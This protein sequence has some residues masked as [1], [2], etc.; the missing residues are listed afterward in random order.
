VTYNQTVVPGNFVPLGTTIYLAIATDPTHGIAYLAGLNSIVMTVNLTQGRVVGAVHLPSNAW[1]DA[2]VFDPTSHELYVAEATLGEV[3]VIDTLNDSVVAQ[4]PAGSTVGYQEGLAW[5]NRTNQIVLATYDSPGQLVVINAS[6]NTVD[7]SLTVVTTDQSVAYDWLTNQYW[8]QSGSSANV[9]VVNAGT[10]QSVANLSYGN[11]GDGVAVSPTGSSVYLVNYTFGSNNPAWVS[12]V[13]ASSRLTQAVYS[14][15][16]GDLYLP[17][18][19]VAVDDATGDVYLATTASNLTE[20]NFTS[21]TIGV[22]PYGGS[23]ATYLAYDAALN[24]M[25]VAAANVTILSGPRLASAA[26]AETGLTLGDLALDP[27][28]RSLFVATGSSRG[29]RISVAGPSFNG[30]FYETSSTNLPFVTAP[31]PLVYLPS[32]NELAYAGPAYGAGVEL[33]NA[34]TGRLLGTAP[35]QSSCLY[36]GAIAV[37]VSSR[38]VAYT[39]CS[40]TNLVE[41]DPVA[42]VAAVNRT[43]GSGVT[44]AGW[45]AVSGQV[46]VQNFSTAGLS[47]TIE[48]L[49]E[50]TLA[51]VGT[52]Q[53]PHLGIAYAIT[54]DPASNTMLVGANSTSGSGYLYEYNA[55]SGDLLQSLPRGSLDYPVSFAYLSGSDQMAVANS[56]D[57]T[58]SFLNATSLAGLGNVTVGGSPVSLAFDPATGVLYSS[59]S[60]GAI[61]ILPTNATG[62]PYIASFFASPAP[63]AVG[64]TTNLTVR[65]TGWSLPLTYTYSGLPPGCT[66]SDVSTL[67]C[68]P[69]SVGTFRVSVAVTDAQGRTSDAYT[70]LAVRLPPGPAI[71]SA[72]FMP[73]TVAGGSESTLEVVVTGGYGWLAYT[74]GHLPPGCASANTS[75]LSCTPGA[76]GQYTVEVEVQ[77]SGGRAAFANAS[78][79]VTA[80]S[81]P[82][83]ESFY[84]TPQ[85]I[86]TRGTS[87]LEVSVSGGVG[88]F[89]FRYVGLPQ[90]CATANTSSLSCTPTVTGSFSVGVNVTDQFGAWA[91]ATTRLNVSAPPIVIQAFTANPDPARAGSPFTIQVTVTGGVGWYTFLFSGLPSG[92]PSLNVSSIVCTPELAQNLTLT[93]NVSDGHGT[94][95][96]ATFVL[97]VG[98]SI[99]SFGESAAS[100][101]LGQST[102]LTVVA[103]GGT[104]TF[105]YS[106]LPAPCASQDSANLTCVPSAAGN[107]TITALVTAVNG[108]EA[109]A[110]VNLSVLPVPALVIASFEAS[111][112]TVTLGSDTQLVVVVT[113]AI[114]PLEFSYANLPPG[115]QSVNS[116]DLSCRPSTEGV[117]TVTVQVTGILGQSV[118]AQLTLTVRAPTPSAAGPGGLPSAWTWI[119]LALV[120]V[121]AVVIG[122]IWIR[123]RRRTPPSANESPP[124]PGTLENKRT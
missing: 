13:N 21:G 88:W 55:T 46:W 71:Q 86:T 56:V 42:Q 4:I 30:S 110:R 38:I 40:S 107:Y 124:S 24:E 25:V 98:P 77:D 18:T 109:S 60:N 6:T 122:V 72:Q 121:V 14:F 103:L 64:A 75:S 58:L 3:G 29:L 32:Y 35:T 95:T 27:L 52:L 34:T 53:M 41:V 69:T 81:P 112:S 15:N 93:V 67:S 26:F 57:G 119:A 74:Y 45:D 108:L 105:T 101:W 62:A 20:V 48:L 8:V 118:S 63:V 1:P 10:L 17:P 33:L 54:Y 39:W 90:G 84:A 37:P 80:G 47:S 70:L 116:S 82:V 92:C 120:G 7:R 91:D 113:G 123:R 99:V 19:S 104:L 79:V 43:I 115:C 73:S 28:S 66:S 65:A 51:T 114:G 94:G 87:T 49:N 23:D 31:E 16:Y 97:P 100:I 59:E 12:A 5:D 44:A 102:R 68:T 2:M 76:A 111:N 106:G 96:S 78:L 50:T 89:S 61:S 83:I 117:F 9:E 36:S 22:G 11:I 85:N